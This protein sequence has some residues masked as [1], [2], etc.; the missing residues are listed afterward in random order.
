MS[1]DSSPFVARVL[2]A[3]LNGNSAATGISLSFPEDSANLTAGGS[4][5][6]TANDQTIWN[7]EDG[8]SPGFFLIICIFVA[9][10][11]LPF[12]CFWFLRHK[13]RSVQ[14]FDLANNANM[15]AQA[16]AISGGRSVQTPTISKEEIANRRDKLNERFEQGEVQKVR[17]TVV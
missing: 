12:G 17:H 15:M 3:M 4:N 14:P 7:I 11:A 6:T 1:S 8:K 2:Q 10:T 16:T 5:A 9:V 13:R